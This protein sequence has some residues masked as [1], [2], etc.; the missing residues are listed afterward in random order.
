ISQNP[1]ASI[2]T[3]A[4]VCS[5]ST[6]N[7]AAV[8]YAG[9][10]ATYVWSMS[11]NAKIT[12]GSGTNV[13]AFTAPASGTVTLSVTVTNIAGCKTSSGN[14]SVSVVAYPVASIT[15]TSSTCAG[16]AG[17]SASV[18]STGSGA[19]YAWSVSNGTITSGSGT[20]SISYTA[21]SSGSVTLKVTVTNSSGCSTSSA[22]ISVTI[23]ASP[24]AIIT[25]SSS[26]CSGSTGNTAWVASA[27]SGATYSWTITGGTITSGSGTASIKYTAGSS[28]S[29]KLSIAVTSSTGC[30]AVSSSV[31][32]TITSTVTPTFAAIATQCLNA[33]PPAL[34]TKSNNGISGT[35]NPSA[36]STTSTG[37]KTYTFTPASGQCALAASI[38]VTVQKCTEAAVIVSNQGATVDSTVMDSSDSKISAMVFPN[39]S[40]GA[41][42]LELKSSV[43]QTVE[44]LVI[45]VMGHG[46][47]H[48]RGEA[49]GTYLFGNSFIKGI[50]FVEIIHQ[51]GIKVLKVIKQ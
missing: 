50:Y 26:V 17:N 35:W 42:N 47:Y 4:S 25:V 46:L 7:I 6:G 23:V 30:K 18:V 29:V 9:P 3:P 41:F 49:T 24:N 28:G 48:T 22:S 44:I 5:S 33:K 12:A 13:I 16:S 19:K 1:I 10:G 37:S 8:P 31:K 38:S 11:S 21:G 2:S 20:N 40:V 34:P 51:K 39:P 27:G 45:D 15:A 36:I 32:V 43:K 14:K